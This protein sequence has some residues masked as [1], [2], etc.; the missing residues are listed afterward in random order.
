MAIDNALSNKE[1]AALT[2]RLQAPMVIQEI[3]HGEGDFNDDIQYALHDIITDYKPDA[4]LLCIA[5][6]M[7]KIAG[8]YAAASP[9][10]DVVAIECAKII[11]DYG[12]V[13]LDYAHQRDFSGDAE[14]SE[15]MNDLE[16]EILC[17]LLDHVSEDLEGLGE[18]L[19]LASDFL[20][21]KN[22]VAARICDIF[23]I[24]AISQAMIAEEFMR[25]YYSGESLIDESDLPDNVTALSA[26]SSGD[27]SAQA[28]NI[29]QFP[30]GRA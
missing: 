29:V 22:P 17:D 23:K 21:G 6:S 7:Q 4:A 28:G 19:E 30:A 5:L 20:K 27:D 16:E 24:Q 10:M 9:I 11:D 18:L 1:L 12:H 2:A 15:G 25:A 13:W 14:A 26:Q 8:I 3:L